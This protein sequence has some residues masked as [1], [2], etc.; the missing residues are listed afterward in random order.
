ME[1]STIRRYRRFLRGFE[2]VTNAQL[3]NCCAGVTLAQ[4]CVLL[5]IDE[6]GRLTMGQLASRL[7]LDNS[8]LSRTIDG[9]VGRGLVERLREDRD[10]RVVRIRL[11][12]QGEAVCRAIHEEND[13]HCQRV[14]EKIPPA[15]RD[16]VIRGFETLVQ[17]YL[18][19]EAESVVG[20]CADRAPSGK[21]EGSS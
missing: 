2:R 15:E 20:S 10:R 18:D 6:G 9:L 7:R 5:E 14:F 13:E 16:A 4:C 19:A 21:E 12:E 1:N 8:T 17:A 11:T 3:K